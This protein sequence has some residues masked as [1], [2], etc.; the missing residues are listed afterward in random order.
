ML[1]K[2]VMTVGVITVP[3]TASVKEVAQLLLGGHIG[4]LPVLDGEE[5]VGIVT[6]SDVL[7]LVP[8]AS[9]LRTAGD[10]MHHDPI[11][12]SEDTSVAAAARTLTRYRIKRAPVIRNGRLVGIVTRSDLLRPYLR[13][14]SEIRAEIEDQVMVRTLGLSPRQIGIEVRDGIVELRGMV[15]TDVKPMLIRLVRAVD[16]VVDITD[17]LTSGALAG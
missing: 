17:A 14:D 11:C 7:T 4:G 10:I 13:T 3:P 15:S 6:S 8:H 1:V 2:D 5:L 16:G 12:L 9:N